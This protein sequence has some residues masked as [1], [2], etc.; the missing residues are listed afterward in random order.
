VSCMASDYRAVERLIFQYAANIDAGDFKAV[1]DLMMTASLV[2]LPMGRA[3]EGGQNIAEHYRRT[4]IVYPETGTP[5]TMHQVTNVLVNVDSVAKTATANSLYTAWQC[6]AEE[7]PTMLSM[8][9]YADRFKR[10]DGMWCFAE[11]RVIPSYFGD[12]SR[13]LYMADKLQGTA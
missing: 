9:H 12:L 7:Q 2:Y 13:H 4:V 10:I 6:L 3:I 11:R 1:G 8:G 5:C